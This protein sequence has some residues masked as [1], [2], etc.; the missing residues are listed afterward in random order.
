MCARMMRFHICNG[1]GDIMINLPAYL[2]TFLQ[3]VF[4]VFYKQLHFSFQPRVAKELSWISEKF[5]ATHPDFMPLK[6][7]SQ[8]VLHFRIP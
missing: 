4:N 7:I 1:M 8:P 5:R 3:V 6:C 2:T